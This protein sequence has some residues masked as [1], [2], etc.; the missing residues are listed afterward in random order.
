[1][2]LRMNGASRGARSAAAVLAILI[3]AI[4]C[5]TPPVGWQG[6]GRSETLPQPQGDSAAPQ[7]DSGDTTEDTGFD[8]GAE[9]DSGAVDA[10]FPVETGSSDTGAGS[11]PAD[12]HCG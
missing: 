1:M 12:A 6:A 8:A 9:L 7:E 11:C 2:E 5:T 3:P 10:T 4:G